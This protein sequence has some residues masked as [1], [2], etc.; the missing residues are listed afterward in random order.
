MTELVHSACMHV[1][2]QPLMPLL[3][4]QRLALF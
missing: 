4:R 1:L 3:V 2:A